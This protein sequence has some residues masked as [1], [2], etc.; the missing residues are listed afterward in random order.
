MSESRKDPSSFNHLVGSIAA[1]GV[2]GFIFHPT[3][4]IQKRLMR[5]PE[6][7][8]DP[9]ISVRANIRYS[10][11]IAFYNTGGK[12]SLYPGFIPYALAYKIFQRAYKF[13]CQK[14]LE[15]AIRTAFDAHDKIWPVGLSGALIGAGE[16]ILL[17]FDIA[18]IRKQTGSNDKGLRHLY[19]GTLCT[20]MRNT[21]GSSAL[22]MTP[23]IY[24]RYY[25]KKT[26]SKMTF[27]ENVTSN[28]L[29][30]VAC[31]VVSNPF[32]VVKTRMQ[33]DSKG[34]SGREIGYQIL[35]NKPS[36]F[37]K[38]LTPKLITQGTKLTFFVTVKDH[39]VE[40]MVNEAEINNEK[41]R[42]PQ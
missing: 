19:R 34:G 39:I 11:K 29:G 8:Y 35:K 3:D 15:K 2:E 20:M 28:A 17:P 24:K 1:A 9:M 7:I 4:T 23:E 12:F 33:S 30:A 13:T 31:L 22:F 37:F 10:I 25:L 14:P 42:R 18:K 26:S 32:D 38:S 6:P 40:K 21:V 27:S 41:S 5:N 36:A 16:V